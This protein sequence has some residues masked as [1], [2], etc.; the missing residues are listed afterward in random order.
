MDVP[1]SPRLVAPLP[2][3]ASRRSSAPR[4]TAVILSIAV[5]L[6]VVPLLI[7][8]IVRA[9]VIVLGLIVPDAGLIVASAIAVLVALVATAIVA[10]RPKPDPRQCPWS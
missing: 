2:S 6:L 8:R 3:L 4:L 5:G 7:P 9:T 1:A 10:A